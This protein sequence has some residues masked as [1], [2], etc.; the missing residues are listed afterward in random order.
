MNITDFFN[1]T[2]SDPAIYWSMWEAIGT[3]SAVFVALYFGFHTVL[4]AKRNEP[5][6]KLYHDDS[7]RFENDDYTE[8]HL[9]IENNGKTTAK[10]IKIRCIEAL[11]NKENLVRVVDANLLIEFNSLQN[12]EHKTIPLIN[13]HDE[14]NA[15]EISRLN[16]K[17]IGRK[18]MILTIKVTGDNILPIIKKYKLVN[19]EKHKNTSLKSI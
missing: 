7:V 6:I 1:C 10:N 5:K 13:V 14:I 9:R 11:Q 15:I 16:R 3:L 2:I 4:E 8:Y 19:N 12:G 17:R 18:D